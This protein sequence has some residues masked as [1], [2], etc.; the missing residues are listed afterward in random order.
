MLSP[1]LVALN[2]DAFI[3]TRPRRRPST[4]TAT[5]RR[6]TSTSSPSTMSR[7]PKLRRTRLPPAVLPPRP[8][9]SGREDRGQR[10]LASTP[11]FARWSIQHVR[12][13]EYDLREVRNHPRL[14]ECEIGE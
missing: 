9:A 2:R 1:A 5:A 3:L 12:Q 4:S 6:Q 8:S 11:F 14:R 7:T 10:E 13:S